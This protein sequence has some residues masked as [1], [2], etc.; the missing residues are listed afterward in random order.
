MKRFSFLFFFILSFFVSYSQIQVGAKAGYNLSTYYVPIPSNNYSYSSLSNFNAGIVV[1]IP[2]STALFVQIE[3]VYS[4]QGA[5]VELSGIKGEYSSQY[6]NFPIMLKYVSPIHL[7]AEAGIQVGFLLG[8]RLTEDG[9]PT[10]NI[11]SQTNSSGYSW[12]FGVGCN[13]PKNFGLDIRYNLA[14]TE[15]PNNDSNAYNDA[16]IK[17]NVFQVGITYMIP[18]L[19]PAGVN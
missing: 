11:K 13:L 16:S 3:S 18:N 9:F 10:A 17:N 7:Y 14:I 12:T 4:G 1:A 15:T 6:L 5:H 8:S 2:M 19:F